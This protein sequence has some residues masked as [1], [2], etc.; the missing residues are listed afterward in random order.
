MSVARFEPPYRRFAI[1]ATTKCGRQ[2]WLTDDGQ[3]CDES[4]DF[5]D[6]DKKRLVAYVERAAAVSHAEN[7]RNYAKARGL[8]LSVRAVWEYAGGVYR[9]ERR[10]DG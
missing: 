4:C 1:R 9:K 3:G 5:T 7:M 10:A 2:S 8:R 6:W